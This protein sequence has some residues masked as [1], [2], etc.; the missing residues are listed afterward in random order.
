MMHV[1]QGWASIFGSHCARTGKWYY[2]V[3]VKDDYKNI[4]FIGRNPGVPESTRGHVRVGYACRYQRYG[5]P[6]GQGNFGFALSDVDG[7]VVNGGTKTRYAKP[8]GRGDVVGCYLSLESSTTEMEDPRK[9]P[10]LHLY[11]QRECDSSG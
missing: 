8:F 7:A 5:M 11:L 2:E 3:T 4:D 9:D 6:V 1:V 10:K